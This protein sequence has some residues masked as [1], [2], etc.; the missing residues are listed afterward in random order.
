MAKKANNKALI[1][2]GVLVGLGIIGYLLYRRYGKK[3]LSI[4]EGQPGTGDQ[5]GTGAQTGGE[6]VI[7]PSPGAGTGAQYEPTPFKTAL[8]GNTFRA[9]V[10]IYHPQ[11]AKD[12]EL[13]KTGAWDNAYI[14]K[15][16]NKW[17]SEYTSFVTK[18]KI[19][20]GS[21]AITNVNWKM[22][23]WYK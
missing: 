18:L 20:I 17:G 16:W 6:A 3:P 19:G 14:R 7:K 15:A 22:Y 11:W 13:D 12:N 5:A 1:I 10:N 21:G 4:G 9:Y 2:G 8:H 23:D